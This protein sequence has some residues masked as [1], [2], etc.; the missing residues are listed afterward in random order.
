MGHVPQVQN[1]RRSQPLCRGD[2]PQRMRRHK[3]R[4]SRHFCVTSSFSFFVCAVSG[5]R[6]RHAAETIS[7][8]CDNTSDDPL[9]M[10]A[11]HQNVRVGNMPMHACP[12][13]QPMHMHVAP[14]L[15]G[16]HKPCKSASELCNICSIYEIYTDLKY[17]HDARA[18]AS[19][20]C[21]CIMHMQNARASASSRCA[22]TMRTRY[23]HA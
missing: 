13:S 11:S 3:R 4:S 14:D 20:R 12:A 1:V 8:A 15:C 2:D 6:N 19:S 18:S 17:V 9:T 21:A 23:A 7:N 22:R 5:G 16:A 10:D